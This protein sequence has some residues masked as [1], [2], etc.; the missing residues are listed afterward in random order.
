MVASYSRFWEHPELRALFPKFMLELRMVMHGSLALMTAARDCAQQ[1]AA[2]DGDEVSAALA[3]YL[4][5]HIA[6][7]ADHEAWL[8]D[9]A[10]FLGLDRDWVQSRPPSAAAATLIGAQYAWIFHS[11]PVALLGYLILL[12]GRP[13]LIEHLDEIQRITGY[14]AEAFRC[15]REHAIADPEHIAELNQLLDEM[16]LTPEHASLVAMSAWHA[17]DSLA[18]LFDDLVEIEARD[19]PAVQ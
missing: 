8:L 6:E 15:L 11:H 7:E 16:P 13:P 10:A 14:P 17:M 19:R 5:H 18:R 4:D 12:E 3:T 2:R 9:D 1:R